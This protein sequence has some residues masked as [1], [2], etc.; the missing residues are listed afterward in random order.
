MRGIIETAEKAIEFYGESLQQIVAIEEMAELQKE[1]SKAMRGK[2]MNENSVA[3][4]IADVEFMLRQLMIIYGIDAFEVE[5]RMENKAERLF[6]RIEIEKRK[7]E[8][9]RSGVCDDCGCSFG[10][11]ERGSLQQNSADRR[12]PQDGNAL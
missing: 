6:E 7:R 5:R 10:G 11:A 12:L 9:D 2:A 1:I 8:E 3:E 4:E